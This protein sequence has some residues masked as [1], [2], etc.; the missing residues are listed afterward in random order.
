MKINESDLIDFIK[1]NGRQYKT[2][3]SL[4]VDQK[5]KRISLWLDTSRNTYTEWIEGLPADC[6]LH[7]DMETKEIVGIDLPLLN[8]RLV[9][10]HDGPI[11]INAGFKQDDKE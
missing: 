11:R 10:D 4:L 1:S 2:C 8:S 3:M 9:V 7:R 5:S 6:G